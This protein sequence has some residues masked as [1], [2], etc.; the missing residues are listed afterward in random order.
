M[1]QIILLPGKLTTGIVG[2]LHDTCDESSI[3]S[4]SL[5][6]AV[7]ADASNLMDEVEQF[8]RDQHGN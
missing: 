2:I 3:P 6:A 5:W 8:L 4:A 7:P 1:T